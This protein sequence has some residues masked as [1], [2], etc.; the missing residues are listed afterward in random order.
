[1]IL[2]VCLNPALQRTLVFNG[3]AL[4]RVNR[5]ETVRLSVGGKGA[6]VARV[7]AALG[8]EGRLLL[9]LGGARGRE[10]R[11][12]LGQERLSFRP[13][14]VS[15]ETRVCTTLLD[16]TASPV[17]ELVEESEPFSGSE[18]RAVQKAFEAF[19]PA[20]RLVVLS[21]TAP[22]GFPKTI[23]GRWI[24]LARRKGVPVLLDAAEP[25]AGP[26]LE[27]KPWFYR[28]NW[29]E[30]EAVLGRS[31][32]PCKADSALEG[33]R[34]MGAGNVLISA[35]GPDAVADMGGRFTV[36]SAPELKPVNSIGSGDAM[37]A[38]IINAC[39]RGKDTNGI[40]RE[41]MACGAANVLT[42]TAGT[43]RLRDVRALMPKIRIFYR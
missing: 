33:L 32:P 34:R 30:M 10:I 21:G 8:A 20:S 2:V 15:G 12:F 9:P 7:L 38:G 43:V 41:G 17:T 29:D 22:A 6:N 26:G 18:V 4:K 39:I 36:V 3:L 5:A 37:A 11:K 31:I 40:L 19:L 28:A 42:V 24:T 14:A 35:E 13:V 1:M 23:Y 25:F 27:A 16:S